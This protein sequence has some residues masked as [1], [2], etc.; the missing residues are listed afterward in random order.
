VL[1]RCTCA[2]SLQELER[3]YLVNT[4]VPNSGEGLKRLD[5]RVAQQ[6]WDVALAGHIKALQ[7]RKPVVLTGD[8]NCAHHEIDI[9]RPKGN[10]R[11][12]GF[13]IVGACRLA[14]CS[15]CML[16]MRGLNI[17]VVLLVTH[18]CCSRQAYCTMCCCSIVS[19]SPAPCQAG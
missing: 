4:Y 2:R 14:Y 10:E 19:Q 18:H 13:T 3:F 12:A 6:G 5:Y 7:Q 8:L 1:H 16:V 11:S 9:H 17:A 15:S